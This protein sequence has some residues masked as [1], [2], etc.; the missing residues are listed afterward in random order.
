M[1]MVADWYGA[2]MAINGTRD[3]AGW[4][5]KNKGKMIIEE[6]TMERLLIIIEWAKQEGL[7]S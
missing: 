1:E 7:A 3:L 6:G 2:G 4:F 5:E